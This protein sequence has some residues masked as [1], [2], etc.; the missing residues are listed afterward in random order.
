MEYLNVCLGQYR[1]TKL[2]SLDD[3]G[4]KQ[5][6]NLLPGDDEKVIKNRYETKIASAAG[7]HPTFLTD[8]HQDKAQQVT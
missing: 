6:A 5:S 3:F 7:R 2:A 8:L 4:S 1:R